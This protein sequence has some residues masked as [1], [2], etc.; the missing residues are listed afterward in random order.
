MNVG[1]YG[2]SLGWT[3]SSMYVG[4]ALCLAMSLISLVRAAE[5]PVAEALTIKVYAAGSLREVM[6][7]LERAYLVERRTA[8]P[9]QPMSTF[10]FLFGPSGKLREKI[11]AGD[12]VHIFASAS[13]SHTERLVAAGKLRSSNVFA[14]NSLC[15][16]ARPDFPISESTLIDTLLAPTVVLGTSTPGADP[17]GDYTWAMFKKIGT[18]RPGAFAALDAK[19]KKMTGAEVNASDTTSPYAQILLAKRADVFV[20]YCTNGRIAQKTDPKI[21]SVKVPAEFDVATSYSIGLTPD[22]PETARDFLRFV[23]SQRAQ[24]LMAELGFSAPALVCGQ[25]EPKLKDAHSAWTGTSI[26]VSAAAGHA[27]DNP[28]KIVPLGPI[29]KR[30]AMT[31]QPAKTLT[32]KRRSRESAESGKPSFGG[33]VEFTAPVSGHM[34]V[35]VDQRAWIDVVRVRDQT[36]ATAVRSDR[37]LGRAGDGKNL[38]FAVVAGEKYELRLSE[39]DNAQ[40]AVLLMPMQLTAT[41]ASPPK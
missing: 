9:G 29:A 34:E 32:F 14:S 31:L 33:V 1:G 13:P 24:K 8:T 36:V 12:S 2:V 19:A 6:S 23:L 41:A 21:T 7:T 30:L 25:V 3:R 10:Q 35:F 28:A 40:A 17:S 5:A 18:V 11:E 4:L 38:G 20:T 22:A 37:W 39:I 26:A 27:P 15:V 16:I